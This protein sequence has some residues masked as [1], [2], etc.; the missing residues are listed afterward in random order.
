MNVDNGMTIQFDSQ[1]ASQVAFVATK[2][3][4]RV[5]SKNIVSWS[6][7]NIKSRGQS[8]DHDPMTDLF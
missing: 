4:G 8:I 5:N 3:E 1:N 6:S 7:S 2:F